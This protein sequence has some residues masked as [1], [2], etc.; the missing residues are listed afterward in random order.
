MTDWSKCPAVEKSRQGQ[1][2]LA[3]HRQQTAR[4]RP[5]RE[6]RGRCHH[7][8]VHGVVRA[9]GR[10]EGESRSARYVADSL[11][12]VPVSSLEDTVN[13]TP[14][15]RRELPG[16]SVIQRQTRGGTGWPTR[17]DQ[18]CRTGWLRDVITTEPERGIREPCRPAVGHHRTTLRGW[19]YTESPKTFEP[20]AEAHAW[21]VEGWSPSRLG[22]A[23][24]SVCTETSER[25]LD[26]LGAL[27]GTWR[28]PR[29]RQQ[30]TQSQ[31]R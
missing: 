14:R 30:S 20:L 7:R 31:R 11:K 10:M 12:A 5:V 8:G 28:T 21:G 13:D 17:P 26:L 15:L 18:Q 16:S 1:R 29:N 25:D 3:F 9:R 27:P 2:R 24:A 23:F 6:P 4:I 22:E 19:R